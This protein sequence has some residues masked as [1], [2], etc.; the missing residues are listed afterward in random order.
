MEGLEDGLNNKKEHLKELSSIAGVIYA[1]ICL[2]LAMAGLIIIH[3]VA[4]PSP[5]PY[6]LPTEDQP[7]R[8]IPISLQKSYGMTISYSLSDSMSNKRN[9]L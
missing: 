2:N 5:R 4:N 7:V 8:E 6:R 3:V 1:G 9:F